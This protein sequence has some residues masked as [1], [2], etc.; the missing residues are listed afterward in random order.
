[1]QLILG[2][3]HMPLSNREQLLREH[4]QTIRVIAQT[5][6]QDCDRAI[7]ELDTFLSR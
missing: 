3:V 7:S 5:L 1:M 2:V 4:N 6:A